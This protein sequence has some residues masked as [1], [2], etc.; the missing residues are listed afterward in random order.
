MRSSNNAKI[1]H[2]DEQGVNERKGASPFVRNT[3]SVLTIPRLSQNI[4]TKFN[5]GTSARNL[6]NL[7][8]NLM[9]KG[10]IDEKATG[11]L[12]QLVKEG[13]Q[14]WLLGC[15][16]QLKHFDFTIELTPNLNNIQEYM[17]EGDFEEMA[18]NLNQS[19]DKFPMYCFIE[20]RNA[21]SITIGKQLQAIEDK[22]EGLGKTAY[23]WLATVGAGNLN[24]FSP[25]KGDYLAQ[26]TWWYGLDD[27]EDFVEELR[28]N[29]DD[30]EEAL[31]D[32]MEVSPDAWE[33][34]FPK[35]VTKI[36]N[37]LTESEL[38]IIAQA[39]PSSLESEV[40]AIVL[41]M[42]KN[43]GATLPDVYSTG[44]ESMHH[45]LY[46][47]WEENDMASR[48]IDD[49]FEGI[50]QHGGEGY[51]ETLGISAIPSKPFLFRQWM[52]A[53]ELGFT[54]LKNIERLI[55]LIGTR[56]N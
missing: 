6:A 11:D 18:T 20:P 38:E 23:Y 13:I 34:A 42:I 40:A 41:D 26:Q 22:V 21:S 27:Q 14:Q 51:T 35:W 47:Y 15:A 55:E 37:A 33:A 29:F 12:P 4:Q 17:Y 19:G 39:Q 9:R 45:G 8:L 54:Q 3:T 31:A 25:W 46:L 32:A 52:A 49:W 50:N 36:D 56:T 44:M 28:Q 24:V 48:L 30:D 5:A 16:G 43:K 10:Y 1:S 53:M 7:A 2:H